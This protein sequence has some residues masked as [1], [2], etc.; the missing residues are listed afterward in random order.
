MNIFG[1]KK[2][3]VP[4]VFRPGVYGLI[5]NESK[6]KIA[7]IE[8][9]DGMYFLPGGGLENDETHEECIRR[10]SMEEIGIELQL[11]KYIGIAQRYFY[12]SND[13]KYYL[14]EGHFYLCSRTGIA[15]EPTEEDHLLRWMEPAKA[16]NCLFHEHQSWAV[17]RMLAMT[18]S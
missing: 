5:F 2:D 3:K 10:E 8:T 12:S 14:S 1:T 16:R 18:L 17:E 6:N 15:G 7:I 4:Y 11:E 9:A 13:Q